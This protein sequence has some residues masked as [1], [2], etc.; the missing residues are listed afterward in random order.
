MLVATLACTHLARAQDSAP[1]PATRA[2]SLLADGRWA[3][4]EAAYYQQS[5]RAPRDPVARA[6]LGRFIAMKGAVRPGM[7]LIAEARKFG[8][9]REVT[10]ELVAPLSAIVE[11]RNET[12]LRRDSVL[13]TRPPSN[14]RA[15][16]QVALPRTDGDGNPV[17]DGAGV[18]EVAWY[19][20]VDRAVGLDS[21]NA[22]GRPIG[23]E[24]FEALVPSVNVRKQ[25][26]T[27]H[28]NARSALSATGHRYQILRTP[29]GIR[30][31][32]GDRRVLP[33][34]DALRELE[35]DWWQ[36]DV[37]HGLLIVR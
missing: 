25:E 17:T 5:S 34:A 3:E 8:L 14:A 26:V 7:V 33:L 21:I 36:V 16:F 29:D 1:L 19:D 37:P 20:V 12:S 35:P 18:T 32:V 28:A 24:V 9:D 27:F 10:R 11:W 4:A 31:L 30:V 15:L 13:A 23:L 22:R 6:A 2:D